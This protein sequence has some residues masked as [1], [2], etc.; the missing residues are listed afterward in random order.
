M[1]LNELPRPAGRKKSKTKRIGRGNASGQGST[2]G[3]G[4]KGQKA[5]S[6]GFHK[7]GFEGGQTPLTRRLPKFGFN[8]IFRKAFAVVNLDQLNAF[9]A[10]AEVTLEALREKRIVRKT[11]DGVKVL[12]RGDVSKALKV[13]AHCFSESA[14]KKIEAAGG[15][16]EV[17]CG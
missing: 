2:A 12:G 16:C 3:R 6:G 7:L 8:N 9:D 10:G 13:K 4:H 15:K 11:L 14:K 17:I 1:R 5:R